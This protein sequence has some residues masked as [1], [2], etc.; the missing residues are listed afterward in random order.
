[1][2][3]NGFEVSLYLRPALACFSNFGGFDLLKLIL[4]LVSLVLGVCFVYFMVA[5]LV[6]RRLWMPLCFN[7]ALKLH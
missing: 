6:L 5:A 2:W 3:D 4:M 1:M 7:A